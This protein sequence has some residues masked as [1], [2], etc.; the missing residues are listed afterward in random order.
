MS[1]KLFDPAVFLFYILLAITLGAM[2]VFALINVVTN[3]KTSYKGLLGILALLAIFG[4]SYAIASPELSDVF[5][6]LQITPETARAIEA[7]CYTCY[8]VFFIAILAIIVSPIV[9]A[10]RTKRSLKKV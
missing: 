9:N 6:K 7:G 1:G 3:F 8:T 5:I 10:I 4:I 2:V